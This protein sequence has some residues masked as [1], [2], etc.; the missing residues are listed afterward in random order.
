MGR[1]RRDS[2]G[3]AVCSRCKENLTGAR[4]VVEGRWLC[5]RCAYE[6]EVANGPIE[7]KARRRRPVPLQDQTLFQLAPYEQKKRA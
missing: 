6:I 4:L 3:V 2:N 7:G 1:V 5:G